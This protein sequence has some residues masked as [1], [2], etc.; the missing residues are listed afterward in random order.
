V[1]ILSLMLLI[2]AFVLFMVAMFNVPARWNLIAGGLAAWV[3]TLI[4]HLALTGT[5]HG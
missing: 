1:D 3:L 4:I 5:F 2:L